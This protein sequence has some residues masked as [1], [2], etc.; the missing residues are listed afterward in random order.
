M[1]GSINALQ[2]LRINKSSRQRDF[3]ST[4]FDFEHFFSFVHSHPSNHL[5]NLS[6]CDCVC[7]CVCVMENPLN[8]SDG[9]LISNSIDSIGLHQNIYQ[10]SLISPQNKDKKNDL[11]RNMKWI[12][13]QT[14]WISGNR[15]SNGTHNRRILS[16]SDVEKETF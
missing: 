10:Y 9:C 3:T 6:R 15:G 12:P 14:K 7:V 13:L 8:D 1:H 2:A 4:K 16:I 5:F 11:I